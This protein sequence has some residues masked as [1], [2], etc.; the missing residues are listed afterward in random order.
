MSTTGFHVTNRPRS[1]TTPA[2]TSRPITPLPEVTVTLDRAKSWPSHTTDEPT[3]D[4]NLLS[5]ITSTFSSLK[6]SPSGRSTSSKAS[7]KSSV[8]GKSIRVI[9]EPIKDLADSIKNGA[10]S[11]LRRSTSFLRNTE[12]NKAFNG[13]LG[14]IDRM[15]ADPETASAVRI[16]QFGASSPKPSLYFSPVKNTSTG[17]L[18]DE[19]DQVT[20]A[21]VLIGKKEQWIL[22]KSPQLTIHNPK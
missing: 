12:S 21:K 18:N 6:R 4:G 15:L 3:T 8:S 11:M 19:I 9:T 5:P 13:E 1:S 10:T 22:Q 20:P 16:E 7:S 14:I 17:T 2:S